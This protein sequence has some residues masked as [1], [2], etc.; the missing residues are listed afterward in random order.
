MD[1]QHHQ[2][3]TKRERR[4]LRHREQRGIEET[5]LRHKRFKNFVQWFLGTLILVIVLSF[6]IWYISMQ[7]A[8][9]ESKIISPSGLHWHPELTIYV[10]GVKQEI[11]ENIGIGIT[12]KPMHTH[13]DTGTIHLEFQGAVRQHNLT[14]GQFFKNW[15][16]NFYGFG[17][18][19]IMTVN[20]QENS[21]LESYAMRDGDKIELR[22][23][24]K[25]F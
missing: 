25:D 15:G 17:K 1:I 2:Q 16:K 12:H 20:G 7:L 13:D 6:F 24:Q 22:Y 19:V 21:E 18:T 14:L 11:P 5:S 23:E 9:P 10:N 4:E 3:L 8:I